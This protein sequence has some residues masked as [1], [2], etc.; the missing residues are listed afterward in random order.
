MAPPMDP[1]TTVLA[2]LEELG[3]KF[4]TMDRK[5]DAT[6]SKIEEMQQLVQ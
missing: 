4:D 3:L 5:T 6:N 2:K 1:L